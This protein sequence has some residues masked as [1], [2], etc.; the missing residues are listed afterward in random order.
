M[1]YRQQTDMMQPGSEGARMLGNMHAG[2]RA[3]QH[4]SEPSHLTPK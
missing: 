4:V 3:T 1:N 2:A